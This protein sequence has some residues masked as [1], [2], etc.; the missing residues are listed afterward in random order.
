MREEQSDHS[1]HMASTPPYLW[2][3]KSP[4]DGV[5]NQIDFITIN[6]RFRNSISQVKTYA[7]ADCNSDHV[8]VVASIK[9]KLKKVKRKQA[10][11]MLQLQLL[12]DNNDLRNQYSVRVQNRFSVLYHEG[13]DG[14]EDANMEWSAFQKSLVETASDIIYK[15]KGNVNKNG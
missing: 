12:K 1:K 7:G 8:P 6:A 9:V 5:R 11:P 15:L 10:R 14:I 13:E 3:W 2:T 4:G